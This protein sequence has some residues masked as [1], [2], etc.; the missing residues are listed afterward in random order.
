LTST[1]HLRRV[2]QRGPGA[3]FLNAFERVE[4]NTLHP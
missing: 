3:A 4:V 2:P 1:R